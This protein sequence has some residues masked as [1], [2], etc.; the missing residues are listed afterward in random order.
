[1]TGL[2][3]AS[4][5]QS[6]LKTECRIENILPYNYLRV[7]RNSIFWIVL[8]CSATDLF[9]VFKF[10]FTQGPTQKWHACII[11]IQIKDYFLIINKIIDTLF[12]SAHTL[13]FTKKMFSSYRIL[14]IYT[15]KYMY[16]CTWS[17]NKLRKHIRIKIFWYFM[18][19][20]GR[21]T[22]FPFMENKSKCQI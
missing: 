19:V 8:D 14:H 5:I 21:I 7:N 13:L 2:W 11:I 1:M 15:T 12:S 20:L 17:Q 6:H 4:T 10:K 3:W 22:F 16:N 9:V 18:L